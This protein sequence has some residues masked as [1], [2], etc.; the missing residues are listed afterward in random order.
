M[1]VCVGDYCIIV[2]IRFLSALAGYFHFFWRSAIRAC[3]V[4]LCEYVQLFGDAFV[5][6]RIGRTIEMANVD[7]LIQFLIYRWAIYYFAFQM[8]IYLHSAFKSFHQ[9]IFHLGNNPNIN[10]VAFAIHKILL[11]ACLFSLIYINDMSI[12]FSMHWIDG[13]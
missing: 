5:G 4:L 12:S 13:T 6:N 11:T 9:I 2:D 3:R 8:I 1:C 7:D 10:G